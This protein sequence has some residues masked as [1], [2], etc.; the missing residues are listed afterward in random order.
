MYVTI[1]ST[2]GAMMLLSAHPADTFGFAVFFAA[3]A[4]AA[5]AV[6]KPHVAVAAP[7]EVNR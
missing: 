3:L 6:R 2:G 1:T 4:A 7:C 5:L